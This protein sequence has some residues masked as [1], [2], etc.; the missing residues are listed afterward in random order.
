MWFSCGCTGLGASGDLSSRQQPPP[1]QLHPTT[2]ALPDSSS[3]GGYGFTT[4][5]QKTLR[6]GHSKAVLRAGLSGDRVLPP[7]ARSD[8]AQRGKCSFCYP[9]GQVSEFPI[10]LKM[11]LVGLKGD[12]PNSFSNEDII[13]SKKKKKKAFWVWVSTE[14][15]YQRWV[16]ERLREREG[17]DAEQAGQESRGRTG[18]G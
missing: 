3:P 16:V 13:F 14:R 6:T 12:C 18:R 4:R 2:D 15:C 11:A 8:S 9:T 17:T 1:P 5:S 10:F 7:Q